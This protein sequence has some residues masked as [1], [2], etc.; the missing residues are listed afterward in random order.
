MRCIRL[1]VLFVALSLVS[2]PVASW[3]SQATH[4]TAK[5]TTQAKPH[6]SNPQQEK[7]SACSKD[8]A[9]HHLKGDER[10]TFMKECLSSGSEAA[11]KT[12]TAQQ[13]KM[14]TCNADA[15]AKKLSGSARKTFMAD[16]LKK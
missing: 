6:A 7:M 4:S 14:K 13:E 10:K 12:L 3:A 9:A 11:E 5:A 2:M 1:V 15:T 16:C 8:A